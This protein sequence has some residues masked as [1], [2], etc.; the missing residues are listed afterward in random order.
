MYSKIF[1]LI[2]DLGNKFSPVN[3]LIRGMTELLGNLAH[4][5]AITLL[6]LHDESK[7]P[8]PLIYLIKNSTTD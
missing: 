2:S 1:V 4:T 5:F 3:G 8:E 7:L 6:G